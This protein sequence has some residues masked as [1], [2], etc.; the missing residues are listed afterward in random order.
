M[1]IFIQVA[2]ASIIRSGMATVEIVRVV[3]CLHARRLAVPIPKY[4]DHTFNH[5]DPHV[6]RRDTDLAPQPE[7]GLWAERWSRHD[8]YNPADP[9]FVA[10]HLD[11]LFATS[12][13]AYGSVAPGSFNDWT[14]HKCQ[15]L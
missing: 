14:V 2:S 13:G 8:P 12:G 10:R 9:V 3:G 6:N 4:D 11:P 5:P 7:L 15:H 1:A